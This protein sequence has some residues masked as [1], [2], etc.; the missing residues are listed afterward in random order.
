MANWLDIEIKV[1]GLE[2]IQE[3][4][5]SIEALLREMSTQR[6][7]GMNQMADTLDDV[8]DNL[9]GLNVDVDTALQALSDLKEQ[10]NNSGVDPAAKAEIM[11][12]ID[13]QQTKIADALNPAVPVDPNA[14]HVDNTLPGDLGNRPNQDLPQ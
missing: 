14:P 13:A 7:E 5:L 4:L 3:T 10:A 6:T 1:K 9:Q 12:L 2:S 11:A 8:R